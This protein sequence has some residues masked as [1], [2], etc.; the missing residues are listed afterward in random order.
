MNLRR[1]VIRMCVCVCV[2][3]HATAHG[4]IL[5]VFFRILRRHSDGEDTACTHA[6]T[7]A[8]THLFLRFYSTEDRE[9]KILPPLY[10]YTHITCWQGFA[11][12][13]IMSAISLC[14][15][16]PAFKSKLL[17]RQTLWF[18]PFQGKSGKREG[19]V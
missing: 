5:P 4:D 18:Q 2:G 13:F 17:Y 10:K 19:K 9:N 7:H 14:L 6:D 3:K 11:A 8:R 1:R 15:P 16:N 12:K